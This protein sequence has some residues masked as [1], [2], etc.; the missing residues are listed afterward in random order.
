MNNKILIGLYIPLIE[1][2]YDVYIP[3][4]KK[5]GTIKR[6]IEEGLVELTDNSYVIKEDSNF[7]SKDN[8]DLGEGIWI[9][10]GIANQFTLKVST[11]ARLL[12]AE[13]QPNFGYVIR[14]GK[15]ALIK[16]LSNE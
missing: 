8:V 3:I 1:K 11:N 12:R 5:I 15:A 13:I 2:S 16:F 14:K 4:N 6:L 9:G 7:Y 10:N